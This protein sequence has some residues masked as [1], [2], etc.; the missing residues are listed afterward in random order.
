MDEEV[1]RIVS[2]AFLSWALPISSPTASQEKQ[3][4]PQAAAI[5]FA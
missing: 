4:P 2:K 1:I 3:A 5:T